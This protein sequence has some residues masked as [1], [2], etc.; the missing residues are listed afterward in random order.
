MWS[1]RSLFLVVFAVAAWTGSGYAQAATPTYSRDRTFR[2]PYSVD[3]AQ[4]AKL[5]EVQLAVS[6]DRGGTWR[7]FA[8]GPPSSE[9]F[10]FTS[11]SDGEHW[12]AVRTLDFEGRYDPPTLT[13]VQPGLVVVVDSTAPT[14]QLRG[15]SPSGDESGIEWDIRDDNVDLTTIRA[16][17]R[18]GTGDWFPIRLDPASSGKARFRPGSRGNIEIRLRVLDKAGNESVE[19]IALASPSIASGPNA[20]GDNGPNGAPAFPT[21]NSSPSPGFNVPAPPDVS[22]P[23]VGSSTTDT[24]PP[25]RQQSRLVPPN[26]GPRPTTDTP[27]PAATPAAPARPNVQLVNSMRFGINYEVDAVGKSGVGSVALYWTYDTTAWNYHGDDEDRESPFFVEVDGE[28]VFGF[29][30]IARSGAGLGDDP[31][32][33]GDPADIWVEVDITPPRVE[34]SPPQPGRGDAQGL[35][36]VQWIVEEKNPA[37]KPIRLS[38]SETAGGPW[39]PIGEDIE[40]TGRYQWRMPTEDAFPYKFF[41]RIE[42]RDRAGNVGR[43]ETAAPVVVDLMK[44]RVKILRVEPKTKLTTDDDSVLPQPTLSLP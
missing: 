35:L 40:N 1:G 2:I 44:P 30:M 33:S 34:L 32:R 7:H 12:F 20:Q 15:L 21:S 17:F 8:S 43:A 42:A 22:S 4:Q 16:E 38:Y 36:D 19:Q 5:K 26:A 31:P 25:S 39:L 23:I 3:A 14:I 27:S 24:P 28:G 18:V 6:T 41:V 29:K 10:T 37:P 13:G 11:T 9:F